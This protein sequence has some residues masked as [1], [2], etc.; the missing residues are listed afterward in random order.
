MLKASE[1]TSYMFQCGLEIQEKIQVKLPEDFECDDCV[2]LF[3]WISEGNIYNICSDITITRREYNDIIFVLI[4]TLIVIMA[5]IYFCVRSKEKVKNNTNL[6]ETNKIKESSSI[7][8]PEEKSDIKKSKKKK[9]KKN[10]IKEKDEEKDKNQEKLKKEDNS[11]KNDES[12]VDMSKKNINNDLNEDDL[13]F[14]RTKK[15]ENEFNTRGQENDSSLKTTEQNSEIKSIPSKKEAKRG[16]NKPIS[17]IKDNEE[18]YNKISLLTNPK[19]DKKL[20]KDDEPIVEHTKPP[21][22]KIRDKAIND[23]KEKEGLTTQT[24]IKDK[25]GGIIKKEIPEKNTKIIP[26]EK[27]K[28]SSIESTKIGGWAFLAAC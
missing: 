3:N 5:A 24:T 4:L 17:N 16:K 25:P 19:E 2:L 20:N 14:V 23:N 22:G 28:E 21:K 7:K 12:K 18:T 11:K 13:T 27:S 10:Y 1:S 15:D 6:K 9:N 8:Q 26:K